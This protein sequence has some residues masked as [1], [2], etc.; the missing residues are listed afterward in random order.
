ML[1]PMLSTL[2]CPYLT[3]EHGGSCN[4]EGSDQAQVC[5]LITIQRLCDLVLPAL[6]ARTCHG[7]PA[8]G[9]TLAWPPVWTDIIS[10]D[11]P[12]GFGTQSVQILR[13]STIGSV[14]RH[15]SSP[16]N[17]RGSTACSGGEAPSPD[18]KKFHV[19][20]QTSN[21]RSLR[22]RHVL[23]NGHVNH[24]V[25]GHGQAWKRSNPGRG[26]QTFALCGLMKPATG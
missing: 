5:C 25:Q 2:L 15:V 14:R 17:D 7:E 19:W 6:R 12:P 4:V 24:G 11:S 21:I 3:D 9:Y 20:L 16:E 26:M 8:V 1:K 23:L 22:T 13:L 10:K 18:R